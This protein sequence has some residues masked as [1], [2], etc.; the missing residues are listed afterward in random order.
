[1]KRW[2]NHNSLLFCMV[3][4]GLLIRLYLSWRPLV[5]LDNLFI[6]D[7]AYISLKIAKNLASGLGI[8]FDGIHLTNGFQCLY[9]F[10][11]TPIYL[12]WTNDL[13]TP[14]H[15]ALTFL[16]LCDTITIFL[17]YKI[18]L[19][20]TNKSSA[21]FSAFL[22]C[23]SPPVI[24][25]AL[26]G[27]ETSLSVCLIAACT[28]FYITNIRGKETSQSHYIILG[29]LFGFLLLARVDSIFFV[30]AVCLDLIWIS[31]PIVHSTKYKPLVRN[32][33]KIIVGSLVILLPWFLIE[34]Y[35]F[36]SIIP[37]SLYSLRL[38]HFSYKTSPGWSLFFS[39]YNIAHSLI[40]TGS[41]YKFIFFVE[42]ASKPL[43]TQLLLLTFLFLCI[44]I[45]LYGL[46]RVLR[47]TTNGNIIFLFIYSLSLFLFYSLYLP[48][49]WFFKRYYHPI[50]LAITIYFGLFF[51]LV[52]N[53]WLGNRFKIIKS[54]VIALCYILIFY[55]FAPPL[56]LFIWGTPAYT[57]D[58]SIFG[59]KGYYTP[60]KE[61]AKTI[62]PGA[63]IG[64]FQSGAFGYFLNKNLVLN[65]D[66]KVNGE[67][68]N[69]LKKH[70]IFDYL[71][72]QDIEYLIAWDL[73][74]Q[75]LLAKRSQYSKDH[76]TKNLE[77]IAD[78]HR[79]GRQTFRIYEVKKH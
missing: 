40:L 4:A 19:R 24:S 52:T 51:F 7:D 8:T 57:I 36:Q 38:Q 47:G 25:N 48:V 6:P 39:L 75:R 60:A 35:Y 12:L 5:Y 68:R 45:L 78:L 66:G 13:I 55:S 15:L 41:R 23:F 63:K 70:R 37:E 58:T 28:Y 76:I 69:A 31:K 26:N 14:I 21:L 71:K 46:Q 9:I 34:T 2:L 77:H 43:T 67:A 74:L 22:W 20:L 50:S 32:F 62:P 65:L 49:F 64:A 53:R 44:G 17:V 79:Q 42:M 27:L 56:R 18:V 73:N 11:L 3:S 29:L 61:A 72:S 30:I 16:S 59:T 54:I 1:M 10:L 33:K